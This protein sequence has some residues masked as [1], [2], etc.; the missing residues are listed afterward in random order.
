MTSQNMSK[1]KSTLEAADCL[2]LLR[3]VCV[4]S[5]QYLC[6]T[7]YSEADAQWLIGYEEIY[8]CVS[9]SFAQ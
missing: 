8:I 6:S 9:L 4:G 3:E 5:Q 7:R 2:G 1:F